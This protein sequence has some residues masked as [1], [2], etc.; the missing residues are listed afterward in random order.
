MTEPVSAPAP[1]GD[2]IAVGILG[3]CM[4]RDGFNSR[5]NPDWR[6]WYQVT[7]EQT[8]PSLISLMATPEVVADEA[9]QVPS[10]WDSRRLRDD[11]SKRML[12]RLAASPPRYL[13][14][15]LSGDVRFGVLHLGGDRWVTNCRRALHATPWYR[16]RSAAGGMVP[17]RLQR[18]PETYLARFTTALDGFVRHLAAVAPQT[19]VVLHR[20]RQAHRLIHPET[21]RLVPLSSHRAVQRTGTPRSDALWAWLEDRVLER[22]RWEVVDLR[23]RE[24]PTSDSHPWGAGHLHFSPDYYHDFLAALHSI[25]LRRT[26]GAEGPE[27]ASMAAF[28]AGRGADPGRGRSWDAEPGRGH[29]PPRARRHSWLDVVRRPARRAIQRGGAML[30]RRAAR[31]S[32]SPPDPQSTWRTP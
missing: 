17:L 18:H 24:Y 8:Q 23:D 7:L 13:V 15:D 2:P 28:V 25:H 19:V 20:G 27:A 16:E 3:S 6:V 11:F 10:A 5:F 4:T 21:G 1:S 12:G 29:L 32:T 31:T 26:A 30:W 14:I 9:L 22:H